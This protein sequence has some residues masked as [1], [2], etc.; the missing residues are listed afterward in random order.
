[1]AKW[2][3]NYGHGLSL[4]GERRRGGGDIK[5]RTLTLSQVLTMQQTP[6]PTSADTG[7]LYTHLADRA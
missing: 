1:M 4:G 7:R 6:L 5:K 3:S 2:A